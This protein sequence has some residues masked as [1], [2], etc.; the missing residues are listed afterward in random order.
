LFS[1][2]AKL[3]SARV[4][5]LIDAAGATAWTFTNSDAKQHQ[6]SA[7]S[8]WVTAAWES[9]VLNAVV[10]GRYIGRLVAPSKWDVALDLGARAI[11]TNKHFAGSL[12]AI[13]RHRATNPA[14]ANNAEDTYRLALAVDLEVSDGSWITVTFGRDFSQGGLAPLFALANLKWGFGEAKVMGK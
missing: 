9:P 12:E 4:G 10:L 8:G 1:Q 14:I 7:R 13:W 5:L 6:W 3:E 2:C 11:A